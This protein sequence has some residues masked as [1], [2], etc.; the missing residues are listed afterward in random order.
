MEETE[1][2]ID[3]LGELEEVRV[4]EIELELEK[5]GDGVGDPV[6]VAVEMG[7][8]MGCCVGLMKMWEVRDTEDMVEVDV[9]VC[10]AVE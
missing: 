10:L 2:V 4:W 6:C 5:N 1:A 8:G 9:R 3:V 7:E